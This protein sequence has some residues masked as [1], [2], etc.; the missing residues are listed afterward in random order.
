MSASLSGSIVSALLCLWSWLYSRRA[1]KKLRIDFHI[2]KKESYPP[3][4]MH[5]FQL[6]NQLDRETFVTQLSS[7]NLEFQIRALGSE[8]VE[9][10]GNVLTKHRWVNRGFALAVTSLLLLIGV[11]I[12]YL[13]RWVPEKSSTHSLSPV[14]REH[15]RVYPVLYFLCPLSVVN[16]RAAS[17]SVSGFLQNAKRTCFAPSFGSR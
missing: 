1:V 3:E 9:L 17:S 13:V 6:I 16:L 12:S 4:A 5:F 11:G 8:I 10:S 15:Q 14:S 7:V 2:D